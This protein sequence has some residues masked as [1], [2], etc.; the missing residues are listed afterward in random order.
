MDLFRRFLELKVKQF[1]EASAKAR[2]EGNVNAKRKANI[3][4][5]AYK[6]ILCAYDAMTMK[7]GAKLMEDE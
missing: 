7:Y 1:E 4:L 2:Q 5:G 3:R 6:E